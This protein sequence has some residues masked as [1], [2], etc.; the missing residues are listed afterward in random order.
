M[1]QVDTHGT[2]ELDFVTNRYDVRTRMAEGMDGWGAHGK[3]RAKPR[4]AKPP[5]EAPSSADAE[6]EAAGDQKYF[7][8]WTSLRAYASVLYL[9]RKDAAFKILVRATA[10]AP[11][12]RAHAALRHGGAPLTVP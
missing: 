9:H 1:W 11:R 6:A 7:S 12:A 8:L 5:A 4:A 10:R 2:P 3:L